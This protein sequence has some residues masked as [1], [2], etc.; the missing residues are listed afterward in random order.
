MPRPVHFEIHAENP[1]RAI[2]FYQSLFGWRFTAQFG[3]TYHL[4]QTGEPGTPGI[5]GGLV[6]RRG[7]NPDPAEATPVVAYCCTIDVVD[8]DAYVAKALSL[9]GTQALPK[10]AI[11]GVGWLAYVKDTES[12]IFGMMQ[13]DP[14]AA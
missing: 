1:E 11:S 9:G 8:V 3:G 10:M 2:G 7:P 12:N 6:P 5:D 13:A 4:I 14:S